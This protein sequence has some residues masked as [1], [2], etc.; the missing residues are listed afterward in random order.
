MSVPMTDTI[1]Q[2]FKRR[3]NQEVETI[4]ELRKFLPTFIGQK[5]YIKQSNIWYNT[6]E[7][8][9]GSI[10]GKRLCWVPWKVKT[11]RPKKSMENN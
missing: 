2:Y 1:R 9:D 8:S 6:I 5:V 10:S 11:Y 4:E 3:T 7:E